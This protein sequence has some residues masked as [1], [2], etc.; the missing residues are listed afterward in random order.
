MQ[1]PESQPQ[2][3][4][5]QSYK[6][7]KHS[8]LPAVVA[9]LCVLALAVSVFVFRQNIVDTITVW[10][11]QPSQELTT[12]VERG[13]FSELGEFYL[14]ASEALVV[15]RAGFNQHCGSLQNEKTVVLGCYTLPERRVYVFD[16]DDTRLDGVKE[17]TAAH[18]MLH[19]A[20]DRLSATEQARVNTLL[21]AQEKKITDTRLLELIAFYNQSEPDAVE[22]ELHSIFGTEVRTLSP[23]LETYYAQ[24]FTDRAAIVTLKEAYEKVLT[25]LKA[26]QQALVAELNALAD[27]LSE[28]QTTYKTAIALLDDDIAAF[29]RWAKSDDATES[30]FDARRAVLERRIATLSAERNSIN[31]AITTYNTKKAELDALNVQAES[32]SQSIDSAMTPPPKL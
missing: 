15:D 28:R 5:N 21:R 30:E 17:A 10:R 13:K 6:R 7:K 9:S 19:A 12:I 8:S 11:F 16:V 14:Y 27:S 31:A 20:Y 22:N 29:N 32:L 24:Y 23:E 18:E 25:D 1:T 4:H 26:Q 3:A 2:L